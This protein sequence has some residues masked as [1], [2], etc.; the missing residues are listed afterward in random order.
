MAGAAALGNGSGPNKH[1]A[2]RSHMPDS[3]F[4]A[5]RI[6]SARVRILR[7]ALPGLGVLIA[8]V[9][10]G[11]SWLMTGSNAPFEAAEVGIVDG[12]LVMANPNLTGYTKDN[13]PYR[14]TANRAIQDFGNLERIALEGIKASLPIED[15]GVAQVQ[16]DSGVFDNAANALT[17]DSPVTIVTDDGLKVMLGDALIDI[18]AGSL[19]TDKQ[20]DIDLARSRISAGS[21]SVEDNGKILV[22]DS[23]VR[24][25]LVPDDFARKGDGGKIPQD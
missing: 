12:K 11:Y 1:S 4:R 3:E 5:A 2:I 22:F 13:R 8:L 16:A 24:M 7:I 10:A 21:L 19:R 23:K 15:G 20:V 25:T 17:I 18:A 14:I 9:F 6:H